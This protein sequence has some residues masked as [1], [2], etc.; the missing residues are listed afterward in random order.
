MIPRTSQKWLKNLKKLA[1]HQHSLG[2]THHRPSYTYFLVKRFSSTSDF[3][4]GMVSQQPSDLL[5]FGLAD[6]SSGLASTGSEG[7]RYLGTI[8]W[9]HHVLYFLPMTVLPSIF[10]NTRSPLQHPSC[11]LQK[12]LRNRKPHQTKREM[13]CLSYWVYIILG[14]IPQYFGR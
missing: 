7:W 5:N 6:P 2:G 4:S 11:W 3:P 8:Y 10:L 13:M 1:P 14:L 12:R 9:A